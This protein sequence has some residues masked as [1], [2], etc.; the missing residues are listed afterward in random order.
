MTPDPAN[1]DAIGFVLALGRALHRYGTPAHRLEESLRVCCQR[2]GLEAEVFTTPTSI[3][4]SFGDPTE[5]R[6]RMMRVEGGELDMGKLADVDALA[7]AVI[8]REILPAEGEARLD[9]IIAAPPRFGHSVSIATHAITAGALAVFFGGSFADV[10]VAAGIGLALGLLAQVAHR[11]TDQARVFE[12]VG[13]AFA[14]FAAG[15]VASQWH[16]VSAPLVTIA[17]LI[18]LLPGMS[19]TVAMTEL[20]TRNLIAGTARLMSAVIVLLELV[21]GVAVGERLVDVLVIAHPTTPEAL[22]AWAQWAALAASSVGMA[23]V[24]QAHPRAFGWILAAC[25]VGYLGGAAGTAVLGGELGA[26]IGAL[27]VG[28]LGNVYARV[29]KRPAQVV[30][31]PAVLLLVPGSMGLRGMT[32]LL[33]HDT[34]SGVETVFAMFVVATAIVAGLLISNAV[35]SPRRIL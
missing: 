8:A 7:D 5:L 18:V 4:M 10:A 14:A 32:S 35:V 6:T 34:L 24:T 23:V 31:V 3:I 19:L 2:L 26:M 33:S 29:L 22:P 1:A 15:I 25:G 30:T 17:A 16:A 11:S 28:V 27:A 13:S 9:A 12:L 20:A 21:I